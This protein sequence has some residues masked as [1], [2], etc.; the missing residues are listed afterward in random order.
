M[1]ST[2]VSAAAKWALQYHSISIP[3]EIKSSSQLPF[4][5]FIDNIEKTGGYHPFLAAIYRVLTS[6]RRFCADIKTLITRRAL[7]LSASLSRM[8]SRKELDYFNSSGGLALK[9]YR[10][11]WIASTSSFAGF[12]FGAHFVSIIPFFPCRSRRTR[13]SILSNFWM[14]FSRPASSERVSL[15]TSLTH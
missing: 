3:S 15:S 8:L 7:T 10:I 11:S 9:S 1:S 4:L 2:R 14:I 5:L 12:R 13:Y 6:G